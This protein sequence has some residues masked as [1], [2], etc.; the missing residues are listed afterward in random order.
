MIPLHFRQ[1]NSAQQAMEIE[2]PCLQMPL[3]QPLRM[4]PR[5]KTLM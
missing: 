3:R 2:R 4:L 5:L 1:S